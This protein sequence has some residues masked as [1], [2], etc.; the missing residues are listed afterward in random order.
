MSAPAPILYSFRRCPYAMRARLALAASGLP[1]RVREVVLRDKPPEML[2]ASPKA[3]VPVLVLTDGRV[4][5]ESLDVMHWALAQN[6][7]EGWLRADAAETARLIRQND[8]PFKRA[9][10]RYK[11]PERHAEPKGNARDAGLEILAGLSA[12]LED[13]GG[14]LFGALPTLADFAI[15]PFVRQFAATDTD[16]W[17]AKAPAVLRR[18]L[19]EH[20][21]SP[22]FAAI[23]AK[24]PRWQAG[25]TELFL[26]PV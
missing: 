26:T 9:L 8:G 23:M 16:F 21:E 18:W 13:N 17:T 3:T 5:D 11:Y 7:P 15:F 12:H 24:L 6:D 25:D 4:I 19:T 2:A 22:R 1:V 14:Q 10:D 20:N